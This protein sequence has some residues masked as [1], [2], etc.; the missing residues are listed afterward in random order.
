MW[1]IPL[2]SVLVSLLLYSGAFRI[3]APFSD[4]LCVKISRLFVVILRPFLLSP[5]VQMH[6]R[7]WQAGQCVCQGQKGICH[8]KNYQR[9]KRLEL[10]TRTSH[11][12]DRQTENAHNDC[13][14]KWWSKIVCFTSKSMAGLST[15]FLSFMLQY[16]WSGKAACRRWCMG[17]KLVIHCKTCSFVSM[18]NLCMLCYT[19]KF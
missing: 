5:H 14:R 10:S 4:S 3:D 11:C 7:L 17:I 12:K 8:T 1:L 15:V 6:E 2:N 19:S 13:I 9:N 16:H 18:R